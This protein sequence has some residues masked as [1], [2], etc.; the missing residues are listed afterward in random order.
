MRGGEQIEVDDAAVM[1]PVLIVGGA[2]RLAVDA[3]RY[4]TV[5]ATGTTA[6]ALHDRLAALGVGASLLLSHG[7]GGDVHARRYLDRADLEA[8]LRAWIDIHPDGVVV[9]SAAVNDYQVSRIEL[10][11]GDDVQAFPPGAKLPS[12]ADELV[13]RL[14]PAAKLIDQL[15][16]WG[17]DGPVIGFKYEAKDT[18]RQSASQLRERTGAALVVAN[19]LCGS[20]QALV[21]GAGAEDFASRHALLDALAQRIAVLAK[22]RITTHFS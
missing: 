19:S 22:P 15:R 5:H 18:V 16:A 7:A 14:R 9:M 21:D 1:R 3:V 10:T 20:V 6:V 4:L 2:P 12:G 11:Y 17:L 13:I 8:E